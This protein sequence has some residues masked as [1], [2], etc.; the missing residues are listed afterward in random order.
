MGHIEGYEDFLREHQHVNTEHKA[1][2]N[3]TFER[4]YKDGSDW[5]SSRS[6]GRDDV[7]VL[8]KVADMAHTKILEF[9]EEDRI[10]R[11]E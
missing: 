2:F 11:Q 4:L 7:L 10:A 1:V 9:E 5:K 3:V 6:F 8:A